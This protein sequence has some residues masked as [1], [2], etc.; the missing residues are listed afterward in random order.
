[1]ATSTAKTVRVIMIPQG[2]PE[3][4]YAGG[5]SRLGHFLIASSVLI[6]LLM[7]RQRVP[8]ICLFSVLTAGL[9]DT[10]GR[11]ICAGCCGL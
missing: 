4:L 2:R 5:I 11:T 6:M 9:L 7:Q 1:M 10:G 3:R 8:S